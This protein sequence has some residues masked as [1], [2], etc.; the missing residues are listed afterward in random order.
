MKF[1]I[2]SFLFCFTS[3]GAYVPKGKINSESMSIYPSKKKCE[4]VEKETCFKWQSSFE[5][6][7]MKIV[8]KQFDVVDSSKDPVYS[9]R[10]AIENCASEV[11]CQV[12]M[13]DKDCSSFSSDH[14]V[15]AD[16][17]QKRIFCHS[18]EYPMMTISREV[19][20]VDETLKA[21]K[22]L[23]RQEAN[24]QAKAVADIKKDI[25]FGKTVFALV[26]IKN[27]AKGLSSADRQA[28]RAATSPI[29]DDLFE[30]YLAEA[31]TKIE[32]LPVTAL[33]TA[34]DKAEFVKMIEDYL[35]SKAQ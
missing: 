17:N 23:K 14:F 11:D 16:Y 2:L 8:T 13:K 22:V 25:D 5:P 29:K 35:A 27:K 6:G 20:E 7:A 10:E 21:E 28:I 4:L 31:K 9:R 1:L 15:A 34:E 26:Q 18:L 12:K 33:I 24:N 3:F 32:A 19:L 30:G